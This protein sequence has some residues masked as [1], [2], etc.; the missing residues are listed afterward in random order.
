MLLGIPFQMVI[1]RFLPNAKLGTRLIVATVLGL[2]L[3]VINF[4]GILSWLQPLLFGGNWIVD[5]QLAAALGGRPDSPGLCLDDGAP[6]SLGRLCSLPTANGGRMNAA[7]N[8]TMPRHEDLVNE[9]L[10]RWYFYMALLFLLISMLGGILMGLQLVHW[11]PL[12]KIEYL[13]AG[14]WR[15]I[16]T[17]AV[18]YGFL[19]NAFLG[20]LHWV[21]PRLTLH[22]VASTALSYFIFFAWQVD[23]AGHGGGDHFWSQ[24]AGSAVGRRA[25]AEVAHLDEPGCPGPG[26]G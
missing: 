17:N 26:M 18:A 21:V 15:M 6:V 24:P 19:A 22:K 14:R 7:A 3:W 11:N 8:T 16:H 13:S 10:V 23:R 25:G 1:A 5:P 2:V 9:R 4:Y 20:M 12:T